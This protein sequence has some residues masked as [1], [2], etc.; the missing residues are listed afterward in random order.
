MLNQENNLSLADMKH[1]DEN[2]AQTIMQ[3]EQ[4][5]VEKRRLENDKSLVST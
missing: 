3:L 5:A 4:I 2:I 1:I